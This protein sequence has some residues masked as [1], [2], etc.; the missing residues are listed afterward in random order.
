[1]YVNRRMLQIPA[2]HFLPFD[3]TRPLR[4]DERFDLAVSVEVGEHLP[5]AAAQTLVESLTRLAPVVLFAASIPHQ[6]GIEHLNEQWPSY[7]RQLFASFNYEVIDCIRKR[8]WSDPQV[9]YWYA[10]DAM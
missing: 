3:L 2:D 9:Q 5:P 7:W 8:V 1:D 4:L 6:G 10:Q